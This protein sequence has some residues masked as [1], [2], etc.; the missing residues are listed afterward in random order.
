MCHVGV[1]DEG[2]SSSVVIGL[3][4]DCN[5]VFNAALLTPRCHAMLLFEMK[6]SHF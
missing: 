4:N 6:M 1:F 2:H 5:R 3:S